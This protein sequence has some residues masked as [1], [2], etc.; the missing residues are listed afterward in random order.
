[1]HV[2]LAVGVTTI[3]ISSACAMCLSSVCDSLP[4]VLR[5]EEE[6]ARVPPHV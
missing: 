5:T 3:E 4:D 6:E 2:I 1:V